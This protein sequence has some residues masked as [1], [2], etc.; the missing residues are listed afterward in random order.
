[1][2]AQTQ[3]KAVKTELMT[4]METCIET[5]TAVM[6][7]IIRKAKAQ[8]PKKQ[9][10]QTV[11]ILLQKGRLKEYRITDVLR[12]GVKAVNTKLADGGLG[13][14][15]FSFFFPF[16]MSLLIGSM[17]KIGSKPEIFYIDHII[18]S[19]RNGKKENQYIVYGFRGYEGYYWEDQLTFLGMMSSP[20][21][22]QEFREDCIHMLSV[23]AN[24]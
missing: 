14:N 2:T 6:T 9:E 11:I 21:I 16:K 19:I 13:S 10:L 24:G 8:N 4:A 22:T 7:A 5:E 3:E 1:M 12:P 18:S 23:W 17:V 20:W 15:R